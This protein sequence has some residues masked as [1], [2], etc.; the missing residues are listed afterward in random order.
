M[1]AIPHSANKTKQ[2][3]TL[4]LRMNEYNTT[5]KMAYDRLRL[6]Y[7]LHIDFALN[8]NLNYIICLYSTLVLKSTLKRHS[9]LLI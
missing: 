3:V 1:I 7:T 5:T 8:V 4:K 2:N 6:F 9:I